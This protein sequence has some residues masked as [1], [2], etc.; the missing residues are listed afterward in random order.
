MRSFT[1]ANGLR[2]GRLTIV[3]NAETDRHGNR[4]FKCQCDC[5]NTAVVSGR[6]LRIGKTSSCGCLY[7]ESR[8]KNWKGGQRNWGSVAYAG[9]L[10]HTSRKDAKRYDGVPISWTP[11][12]LSD[13]MLGHADKCGLC[14]R[15]FSER[16]RRYVDHDHATGQV[17]GIVCSGCNHLVGVIET[18]RAILQNVESYLT[19]A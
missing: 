8:R 4:R 7:K 5:G 19:G 9:Q 10:I 3:S 13:F 16:R 17:R 6:N 2:F 12:Q 11:E 14:E 1:L 15:P 18:N